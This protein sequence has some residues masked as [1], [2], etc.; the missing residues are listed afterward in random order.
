MFKM[1][2]LTSLVQISSATAIEFVLTENKKETKFG[3]FTHSVANHEKVENKKRN[4]ICYINGYPKDKAAL[5][6][7]MKIYEERQKKR[8]LLRA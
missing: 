4:I 6:E 2:E 1:I 3:A 5:K 7:Y 8:A